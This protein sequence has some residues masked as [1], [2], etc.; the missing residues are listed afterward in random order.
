VQTEKN[1]LSLLVEGKQE[2]YKYLYNNYYTQLCTYAYKILDDN[3]LAEEF[4]QEVIFKIW[5]NRESLDGINSLKSYLYR[6]VHNRILNYFKHE[7]VKKKYVSE[8]EYLLGNHIANARN[9]EMETEINSK[10]ELLLHELPEKTQQVI[11][12]KY[13]EGKKHKEIKHELQMAERTIGMHVSKAIS[14]FKEKMDYFL[15][16]Q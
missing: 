15:N 16:N 7:N 14:F 5:E 8:N 1:I 9:F 4:V 13:I 12:L 10:L 3:D 6:S 11:K 2:A